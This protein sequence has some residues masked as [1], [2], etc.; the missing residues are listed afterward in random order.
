MKT[1]GKITAELGNKGNGLYLVLKQETTLPAGTQEV[2][3]F[4]GTPTLGFR[5]KETTFKR[6]VTVMLNKDKQMNHQSKEA[7]AEGNKFMKELKKY[8]DARLRSVIAYDVR[9][10]LSELDFNMLKSGD[11]DLS[12]LEDRYAVCKYTD[13]T[14]V[15]TEPCKDRY[16][17]YYYST[18]ILDLT[19]APD[20]DLRFEMPDNI[21]ERIIEINK[22]LGVYSESNEVSHLTKGIASDSQGTLPLDIDPF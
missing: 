13:D 11:T 4:L 17:N 9:A 16:G 7:Q 6:A 19:G 3:S 1:T 14:R 12:K 21:K 8:P 10:I 22:V 18:T 5:F 15:T 20:L 2:T